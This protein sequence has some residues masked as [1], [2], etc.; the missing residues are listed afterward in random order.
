MTA[1]HRRLRRHIGIDE[2]RDHRDP[3]HIGEVERNPEGVVELGIAGKGGVVTVALDMAEQ[4]ERGL[5]GDRIAVAA[6]GKAAFGD[7]ADMHHEAGRAM[8]QKLLGMI[9]ADDKADIGFKCLQLLADIAQQSVNP[10]DD[11]RVL[12]F[13]DRP[14]LRRMGGADPANYPC[15]RHRVLQSVMISIASPRDALLARLGITL[16]VAGGE[17]AEFRYHA[18]RRNFHQRG[19]GRHGGLSQ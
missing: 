18:L 12:R 6:P 14:K 17:P 8:Q 5:A 3:R 16:P 13:G 19:A 2:N 1:F 10:F 15:F 4:S 7:G 9:V 11:C